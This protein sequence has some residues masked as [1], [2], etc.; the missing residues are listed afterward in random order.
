M[1]LAAQ[2]A[3]LQA[4]VRQLEAAQRIIRLEQG[5]ASMPIPEFAYVSG[6]AIWLGP[7]AK[8]WIR[9]NRVN[10]TA[11]WHDGPPPDPMPPDEEWY[12]VGK[13]DPHLW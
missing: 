13:S 9:C 12:E 4:R 8:R 7:G 11:E 6:K 2:V 10:V 3:E 1:N 5:G